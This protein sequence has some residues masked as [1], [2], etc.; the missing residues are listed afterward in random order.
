MLLNLLNRLRFC[1]GDVVGEGLRGDWDARGM[2]MWT[3]AI[4]NIIDKL[5]FLNET[6]LLNL[7]N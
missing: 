4:A 3:A 6:L 5:I 2:G 1:G 7:L